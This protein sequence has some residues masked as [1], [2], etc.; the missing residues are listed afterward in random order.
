MWKT[1]T[2]QDNTQLK[3]SYAVDL[4][5]QINSTERERLRN[6]RMNGI[7]KVINKSDLEYMKKGDISLSAN[8]PG[9]RT[10]KYYLEKIV[11]NNLPVDIG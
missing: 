8:L 5:S 7:E 10:N 11:R 2:K 1:K 3:K 9:W 4:L 6:A